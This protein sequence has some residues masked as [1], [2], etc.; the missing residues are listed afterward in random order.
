MHR[1]LVVE[2]DV[3][4]AK[5]IEVSFARNG[6]PV[7]T[8]ESIAEARQIIGASGWDLML[9]D[10]HLPD[11]D[12]IELCRDLRAQTPHGYIVIFTGDASSDA[13]LAGFG[14][15]ADDY[16]TK[17]FQMDELVARVRA[18]LRIVDLQKQLL[19]S[20][21]RLEDLSNSDPLT[22]L[23]NRR[24]FEKEMAVRFEH[25]RRY[26]RPMSVVLFD[27]DRFKSINDNYGHPAG[28]A[29]LRCVSEVLSKST[30]QSDVAARYGGEEFIVILPETPLLEALQ[31]AEKIRAGV[32]SED[33]RSWG[34]EQVTVS[35]GVATVP[36]SP[37]PSA[38]S[39]IQAAD[40]ALYRA[41]QHGR[42][43]VEYERRREGE[44]MPSP[45]TSSV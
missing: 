17:P 26:E 31:F 24:A 34:P 40:Q 19:A 11:G 41:K 42:N 14:C 38:A 35:G 6:W 32:A 43:R 15:G 25:A 27:V 21:R 33:V 36:Y 4:T 12:G 8:A 45:V 39:M 37:F 13:K 44:R 29:V 16:V 28:D 2:D 30:R 10:R 7:K 23:R 1:I 3:N 20:N 5:L 9:L 22:G 18:G